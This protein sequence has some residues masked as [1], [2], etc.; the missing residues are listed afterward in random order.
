MNDE[1][2]ARRFEVVMYDGT[3]ISLEWTGQTLVFSKNI[4]LT[5]WEQSIPENEAKPFL[6]ALKRIGSEGETESK[7]AIL[8]KAFV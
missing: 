3:H 8:T 1:D 5:G 4:G 7:R 6:A 2:R